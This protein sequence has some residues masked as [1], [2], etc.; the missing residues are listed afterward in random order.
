MLWPVAAPLGKAAKNFS[1]LPYANFKPST[2]LKV[3]VSNF[4]AGQRMGA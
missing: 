4:S 3:N 2:K 1:A